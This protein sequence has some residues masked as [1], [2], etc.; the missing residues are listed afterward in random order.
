MCGSQGLAMGQ[1]AILAYAAA[2][3]SRKDAYGKDEFSMVKAAR[4]QYVDKKI[5]S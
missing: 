2:P 1:G 3:A 4:L 5:N